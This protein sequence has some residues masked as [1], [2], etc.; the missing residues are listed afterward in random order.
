MVVQWQWN[1]DH[2]L[3]LQDDIEP[4][5]DQASCRCLSYILLCSA[6]DCEEPPKS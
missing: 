4:A 5:G 6:Q 1:Q 2:A 3:V